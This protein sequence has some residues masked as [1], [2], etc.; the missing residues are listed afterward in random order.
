MFLFSKVFLTLINPGVW[1]LILLAL[2]GGLLWTRWRR[3]GRILLSGT[4]LFLLTISV[5]PIGEGLLA[6]LEDRFPPV[7][8]LKPPVDGIIVLGGAVQQF[9]TR[10]RGQ[11]ALNKHA[12]R[13]TE[14]VGLANRFPAARL[15]YTGGS[16]SVFGQ[17]VKETEAARLFFERI[18]LDPARVSYEGR[19]RNTYESA[20]F[21]H[22]LLRPRAGERWVLVTSATHMP[23]AI[24]TFRKAGWDVLPYP[25]D[26]Q[27][28]GVEHLD[29]YFNLR[30]ALNDLQLALHEWLGLIAYRV[31]GRT[32]TLFPAP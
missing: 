17:G 8:S 6:T 28:M 30:A 3:A 24:G 9:I 32:D 20:L 15:A 21:S 26:Y 13:M 10:Q 31:L 5:L 25:V 27:T 11:T 4:I 12:E 18:G 22:R 2:G 23:R 29:L 1:V 16:A 7:R 19:S 14:F